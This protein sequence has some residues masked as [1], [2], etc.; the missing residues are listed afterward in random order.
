[1]TTPD[2][3][4]REAF[5]IKNDEKLLKKA[6]IEMNASEAGI[7][8]TK[9]ITTE[10]E[11]VVAL[12]GDEA[13]QAELGNTTD[14]LGASFRLESTCKATALPIESYKENQIHLP[15]PADSKLPEGLPSLDSLLG[16]LPPIEEPLVG[17]CE[18][19][20]GDEESMGKRTNHFIN[21]PCDLLDQGGVSSRR[22]I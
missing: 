7:E 18:D 2:S 22:R 19:A 3:F 13:G 12:R 8:K 4:K 21:L 16:T 5:E 10:A 14:A 1:M 6:R 11:V 9:S 15:S 20:Y 17:D